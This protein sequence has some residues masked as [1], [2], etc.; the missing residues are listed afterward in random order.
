[1]LTITLNEDELLHIGSNVTI[2]CYR[3]QDPLLKRS[4]VPSDTKQVKFVIDAPKDVKVLRL[5]LVCC[6][7]D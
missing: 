1:M 5:E 2:S 4:G 6:K 3:H 7:N